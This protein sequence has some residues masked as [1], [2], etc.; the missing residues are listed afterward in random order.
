MESPGLTTTVAARAPMGATPRVNPRARSPEMLVR[1]DLI[2]LFPPSVR[3]SRRMPVEK[4]PYPAPA[5]RVKGKLARRSRRPGRRP[6]AVG[7]YKGIAPW[8]V[9]GAMGPPP[10][11]LDGS[12]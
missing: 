5:K 11:A 6:D 12:S 3:K 10:K 2:N 8:G 4:V 7:E 9:G 1:A